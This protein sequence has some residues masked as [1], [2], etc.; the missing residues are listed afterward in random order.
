MPKKKA[1][2]HYTVATMDRNIK[3]IVRSRNEA[4]ASTAGNSVA[5]SANTHAGT[6]ENARQ[7]YKQVTPSPKMTGYCAGQ[8]A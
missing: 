3:S 6:W 7:E 5:K 8:L 4:G 1:V 2:I